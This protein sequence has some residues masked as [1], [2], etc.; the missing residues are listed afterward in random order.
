MK[1]LI[2]ITLK[3]IVIPLLF[4]LAITVIGCKNINELARNQ[5]IQMYSSDLSSENNETRI[6]AMD[7]LTEMGKPVV[8]PLIKLLNDKK[9]PSTARSGAAIILGDIGD[10]IAIE[11]LIN[12]MTELDTDNL[13]Y[14]AARALGIMCKDKDNE[15]L[16]AERLI[17]LDDEYLVSGYGYLI[18]IGASGTEEFLISFLNKNGDKTMAESFIAS[19]NDKLVKAGREWA[20]NRGYILIKIISADSVNTRWGSGRN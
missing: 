15:K 1:K 18:K 14:S 11:P 6:S 12:A 3:I 10:S 8:E 7:A 9:N 16:I 13:E 2:K 17:K 20:T 4:T 19:G 5:L